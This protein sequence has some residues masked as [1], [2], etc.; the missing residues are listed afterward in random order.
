MWFFY[1]Y[2]LN[3]SQPFNFFRYIGIKVS[4]TRKIIFLGS[5]YVLSGDGDG[6]LM[7]IL[8]LVFCFFYVGMLHFFRFYNGAC[9]Q[10]CGEG[11]WGGAWANFFLAVFCEFFWSNHSHMMSSVNFWT[12]I[13][14]HVDW[15]SSQR[16]FLIVHTGCFCV[17][18]THLFLTILFIVNKKED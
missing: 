10:E 18:V 7:I 1:C 16:T 14:K 3:F 9:G 12:W 17:N 6:S 15:S 11:A 13:W 8:F 5:L 2:C 4:Y